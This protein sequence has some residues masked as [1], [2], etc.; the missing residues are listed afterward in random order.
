MI[1]AEC[2]YGFK[3]W[4]SRFE[5]IWKPGMIMLG[6]VEGLNAVGATLLFVSCGF[7]LVLVG[8]CYYRI[9]KTPAAS[10]DMHGPLDIDTHDKGT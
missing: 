2:T 3:V 9:M 4:E 5:V 1:N 10:E 6:D 7:V 8:F